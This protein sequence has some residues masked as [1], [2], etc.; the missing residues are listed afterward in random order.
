MPGKAKIYVGSIAGCGAIIL[1]STWIGCTWPQIGLLAIYLGLGVAL[2]LLKLR[3]PGLPGTYSLNYLVLLYGLLHFDPG[4]T[5]LAGC[6]SALAQ[7]YLNTAKRPTPVQLAFNI[8]NISVSLQVCYFALHLF[9]ATGVPSFR[10]AQI[11]LVAAIYFVLNTGLVSGI[12]ALLQGRKLAEIAEEWYVW[13]F[14][15]YLIGTVCVGCLP[16]AS[17]AWITISWL[18]LLP[19]LFLLHFFIGLARRDRTDGSLPA[20]SRKLSGA[21]KLFFAVV[22]AGGA[23]AL[24]WAL[25]QGTSENPVRFI[26]YLVLA[27]IASTWKVRLPRMV[28]TISVS[29]VVVLVAVAKLTWAEIAVMAGTVSLVQLYW[30]SSRSVRPL[31]VGFNVSQQVLSAML[32]TAVCRVWLGPVL[33]GSPLVSLLLAAALLY[34]SSSLFVTGAL[35]GVQGRPL[36]ELWQNTYFYVLPYYLVGATASVLM[37][38]AEAAGGWMAA[39][40]VLPLM[41]LVYVSY[42][43][44]VTRS[45]APATA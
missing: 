39:A 18:I 3:L 26:A 41:A 8:G 23:A 21:A 1:A 44:H 7:S 24:I 12:L 43:A 4:V 42:R 22:L 34:L 36:S 11:A 28:G 30:K 5:M 9:A 33:I 15:Y 38:R 19:L 17:G 14:P 32:A 35:C 29:F 27:G 31:Q 20:D 6:L 13:S 25:S 2:S 16:G 10:P 45:A 40:A 37:V